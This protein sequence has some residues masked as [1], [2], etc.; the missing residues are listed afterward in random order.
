MADNIAV[1]EVG[2]RT[3]TRAEYAHFLDR[4]VHQC[5]RIVGRRFYR[6]ASYLEL[7]KR[8]KLWRENGYDSFESYLASLD[9]NLSVAQVNL[10]IRIVREFFRNRE[11]LGRVQQALLNLQEASG[12][13]NVDLE[14]LPASKLD[15][16]LPAVSSLVQQGQDAKAAELVMMARSPADGGLSR[17]DL[18]QYLIELGFKQRTRKI[19]LCLKDITRAELIETEDPESLLGD[20]YDMIIVEPKFIKGR[21]NLKIL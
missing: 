2:R 19:Y 15:D 14:R 13:G 8:H 12:T 21:N 3:M 9:V 10:G 18:Q 4:R 6:L 1:F 16:I 5:A 11:L 7:M 20:K 17:S